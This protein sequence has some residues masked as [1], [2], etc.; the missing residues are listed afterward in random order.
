MEKAIYIWFRSKTLFVNDFLELCTLLVPGSS[1]KLYSQ[2][3]N[4]R[5]LKCYILDNGDVCTESKCLENRLLRFQKF[6]WKR[7]SNFNKRRHFQCFSI[8]TI[9][10]N[11]KFL[12]LV[13]EFL[14][15]LYRNISH[16]RALPD[17]SNFRV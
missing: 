4:F 7:C 17:F 5:P 10:I 14:I 12:N 13:S 9:L 15:L 11:T 3:F 16:T 6:S 1:P 8:G 2:L